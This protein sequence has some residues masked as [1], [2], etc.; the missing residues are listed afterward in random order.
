MANEPKKFVTVAVRVNLP[1]NVHAKLKS[2]AALA[3]QTLENFIAE[4]LTAWTK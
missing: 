4:R 1:E 3:K 2:A